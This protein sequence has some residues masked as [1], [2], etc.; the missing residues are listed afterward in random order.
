VRVL[1]TDTCVEILRGN[2]LVAERRL[3]LR[4]IVATTWITACELHY[5]AACSKDPETNREVVT[6]FLDSILV[7]GLDEA[8]A[9]I[10]G[11][12]KALLRSEGLVLDDADL[13]IG[14]ITAARG[15]TVVTGNVRHFSRI[16][17][18]GVESWV[19]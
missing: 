12:L 13:M 17:G 19:R 7:L 11:E 15:A 3:G 6:D 18:I 10:F 14:S 8:S 5:G 4:D 1:D 9:Q 16:P 2:T